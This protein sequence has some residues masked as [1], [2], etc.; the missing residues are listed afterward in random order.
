[1]SLRLKIIKRKEYM[2]ANFSG[3]GSLEKI[4][5]QFAALA[6]QCRA[7]KLSK[8]LINLSALKGALTFA[9]RY[10][11][12]ERAV[13]FLAGSIKVAVVGTTDQKDPGLLGEMVARNRGVIVRVFTDLA[14]AKRWLHEKSQT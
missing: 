14:E 3:Q 7:A 6:D 4:S 9:A 5:G 10:Q 12:G 11:A 1:M 8:L 2:V 13:T